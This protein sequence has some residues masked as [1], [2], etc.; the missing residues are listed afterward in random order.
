MFNRYQEAGKT[1]IKYNKIC[2]KIV[3]YDANALYLWA[4]G[5]EMPVGDYTRVNTYDLEQLKED[6]LNNKLFGFIEVDIKT[7]LH[8][9]QY[10][11]DMPPT[12]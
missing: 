12:F 10:F 2:K 4:I 11:E 1:L 7:P 3:G 6:I 9:E 5:Q 8:L